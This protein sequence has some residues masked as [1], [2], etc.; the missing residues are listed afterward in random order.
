MDSQTPALVE[1]IRLALRGHKLAVPIV[2]VSVAPE[3]KWEDVPAGG[4]MLVR[5]LCWNILDAGT[6]ITPPEFEILHPSITMET[7]QRE[8]P[9]WLPELTVMVDDEVDVNDP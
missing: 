6:E 5:W 2:R 8:L 4:S 7:L 9:N 1:R 3:P